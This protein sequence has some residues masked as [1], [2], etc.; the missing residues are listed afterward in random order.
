[1]GRNSQDPKPPLLVL[2]S[3]MSEDPSYS[4]QQ[5]GC[6][7]HEATEAGLAGYERLVR[8]IK[9]TGEGDRHRPILILDGGLGTTLEDEYQVA[10]SSAETPT[11]SSHLL[12]SSP[13]TLSRAHRSFVEAGADII[14]TA[15]YQASFDGFCR[16]HQHDVEAREVKG[17]RCY[18]QEEAKEIMRSA[19]FLARDAFGSRKKLVALSLGAYGATTI[20]STEY[21]GNYPPQ[22]SDRFAL[23]RWHAQRVMAF[24]GHQQTWHEI[25]L[26]AFETL[27]KVDEIHAV[28]EA[29]SLLSRQK[30]FWISCVFPNDDDKLPDGSEV[31][32]VIRAM[33]GQR[34]STPSVMSHPPV[35]MGVGINCTKLQKLKGLIRK[36]ENAAAF[37][38]MPL[39]HLVIYPDG[40]L[41][42]RY[43]ATS[44]QWVT[45][46]N[47]ATMMK[48]DEE[49]FNM[50]REV[51]TRNKWAGIIV[52]GCC[53]TQ[54]HNIAQLRKRL[55]SGH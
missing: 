40:A 36:Y 10:F 48:W 37:M 22:M 30:P 50:V 45:H 27:P 7:R 46:K 16:T 14:L 55:D 32:D 19:V 25:D 18:S 4:S 5:A 51:Q 6:K 13:E 38:P 9:S 29:M 8:T 43:D 21:T 53:K 49:M 33:L 47:P 39:P 54:P 35:P 17:K 24:E 34:P 52:G 41:D 3:T 23:E 28:R 31:S 2:L 15:T 1:M 26:V 20:P 12:I 42:S 44:Q 11:W